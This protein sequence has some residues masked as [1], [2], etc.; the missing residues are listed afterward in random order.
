[1]SP[2]VIILLC[3][4]II[5]CGAIL[6]RLTLE[7]RRQEQYVKRIRSSDMY[8]HLYPLLL[9]CNRRCVESVSIRPEEVCIRLYAPAGRS[10][11]YTFEKHGFDPL[12]QEPLYA[13]AQAIAVD[14]PLLRDAARYA[15]RTH[16]ML[17]DNG[18]KARW[19][20]YMIDTDYKDSMIRAKYTKE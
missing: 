6:A 3:A 5:I 8:G 1:M 20:E 2:G 7:K 18:E 4:V 11:H 15:F 17:L 19:Y 13:L 14:L 12:E 9:R 16:T 10:L